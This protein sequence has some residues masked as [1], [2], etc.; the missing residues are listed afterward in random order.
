M[1]KVGDKCKAIWN[2]DWYGSKLKIGDIYTVNE[3]AGN[4]LRF[5]ESPGTFDFKCVLLLTK[6]KEVIKPAEKFKT[7]AEEWGF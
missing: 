7:T 1:F 2:E 5:I 4:G 6:N 3:L